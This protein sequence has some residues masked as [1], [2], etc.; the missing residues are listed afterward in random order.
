MIGR[1]RGSVGSAQKQ[2]SQVARYRA[3]IGG[4]DLRK[5]LGDLEDPIHCIYTYNMMPFELGMRVREGYREWALDVDAGANSG[6]H[7]LI[8]FDS[9]EENNVGDKLFAVNNEGIW[10]VTTYDTAPTQLVTFPDQDVD[11]GYGTF[12]HY[13][14][15]AENDVLFYADNVNG[16][17]SY[18]GGVWTNT[19]LVDGID[20]ADV[21]FVMSHKNNIWFAVKNS[22]VGYYLD[23]L[24]T[25]GTVTASVFW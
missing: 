24:S 3:P 13:V 25:T 8:P 7:T 6:V 18:S 17:Y 9:A 12:T 2:N 22:T 21:K 1:A 15:Q 23:I 19:N 14:D 16:L 20:E 11:A 5:S 4:V 10:D